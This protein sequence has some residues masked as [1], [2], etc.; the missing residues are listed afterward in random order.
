M[1]PRQITAILLLF[2]SFVLVWIAV[3]PP[4]ATPPITTDK[5]SGEGELYA[6]RDWSESGGQGDSKIS[7]FVFRDRN[8]NGQYDPA[9]LPM[10]SVGIQVHRPN[11]TL[12]MRSSNINGYTNFTMAYEGTESDIGQVDQ[13]HTFE[14]LV[15]PGFNVTTDNAIQQTDFRHLPG[16]IG[17]IIAVNP[18]TVIGLA[19]KLGVTGRIAT[20][21][22]A[23]DTSPISVMGPD[24]KTFEVT[25]DEQGRFEFPVIPGEWHL[26]ARSQTQGDP[27][28]R[29]FK[30]FDAPLVLSA[31]V[32]GSLP[33]KP[34]G[35]ER[36]EGFEYLHRAD[37]DKIP[38]GHAGL[39][40]NYLLAINNQL[41]RGPGYVN[42]LTS[43]RAVAYN[44]SG[45]PV[46]ISALP[47]EH[48]DFVGAYF[49]VAWPS[50]EGENLMVEAWREGLVVGREVLRLSHLGPIWFDA[51][52]RGIDRL[53]FTTAHYWQFVTDDM[54]FRIRE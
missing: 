27:F 13:P 37:I 50:A 19:P 23:P 15:P 38:N 1:K 52:Y 8:R 46:T 31:I 24:G 49:G 53:T 7:V 54:M 6:P 40:W 41:Y 39:N 26:L 30:V 25:T 22:D 33:G 3:F 4:R 5:M 51:D 14:V 42:T 11:G 45:H 43:G 2:I 36:M 47:G 35:K 44:S 21:Q 28:E 10:A 16:A 20:A 12:R 29:R 17:D 18:P 9:D 32:P 48:F 34:D